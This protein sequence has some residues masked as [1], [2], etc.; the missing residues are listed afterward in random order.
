MDL[1]LGNKYCTGYQER[2]RKALDSGDLMAAFDILNNLPLARL[3]N[4]HET[5]QRNEF[6]AVGYRELARRTFPNYLQISEIRNES[7]TQKVIF[8]LKK[9]SSDIVSFKKHLFAIHL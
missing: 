9:C 1:F 2:F 6:L 5:G 8:R 4:E 7:S 3:D